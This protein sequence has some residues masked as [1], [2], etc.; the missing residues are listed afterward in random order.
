MVMAD[1]KNDEAVISP[2]QGLNLPKIGEFCI[3]VSSANDLR[4][5]VNALGK[6]TLKS[7]QFF[8]SQFYMGDNFSIVGPIIGSSYCVL[9]M[10]NLV[11]MGARKILF[12]GWCGAINNAVSIGDIVVPCSAF[13]DE[14][15]SPGYG[16]T[17]SSGPP[18]LLAGETLEALSL[19]EAKSHFSSIWTTDA[20]YR[21]THEKLNHFHRLGAVA[22]EMEVSALFSAAGYRHVDAAAV[23]AVSDEL[24][25]ETWNPGFG[26]K[27]FKQTCRSICEV[28]TNLCLNQKT[29][30]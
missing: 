15:T 12:F 28:L 16:V 25:H 18:G 14:G 13:I 5:I 20:I 11:A 1:M 3:M 29:Q 9:L 7:R 17:D 21:E 2:G 22:V 6:D 4:L 8:M 19:V 24:Y 27:S 30:P 23:L 26:N 10:E